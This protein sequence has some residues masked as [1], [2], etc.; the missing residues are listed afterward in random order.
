M[1]IIGYIQSPHFKTPITD[2][3]L[4][5]AGRMIRG[6]AGSRSSGPV[7]A[8]RLWVA[9]TRDALLRERGR[10]TYPRFQDSFRSYSTA[11]HAGW[12]RNGAYC[13]PTST[14]PRRNELCTEA[15][16]QRRERIT[17]L[18]WADMGRELQDFV[19]SWARGQ[20]PNPVPG[21]AHTGEWGDSDQP[22]GAWT[23]EGSGNWYSYDRESN[24][25][26]VSI[27][28]AGGSGGSSM[29]T[30]TKLIVA[31]TVGFSAWLL[32]RLTLGAR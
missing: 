3:D 21:A 28:A 26:P 4:L 29:G 22:A 15:K 12:Q 5:W 13:A 10:T 31:G 20:V 2:D 16:F 1:S 24:V 6:S 23:I 17:R 27:V 32:W 25:L 14:H 9:A 11:I 19:Y 18:T 8:A 30:G 7:V